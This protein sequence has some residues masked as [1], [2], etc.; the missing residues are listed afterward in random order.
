LLCINEEKIWIKCI[1]LTKENARLI[2]KHY[3]LLLP[4]T[5]SL[6]RSTFKFEAINHESFEGHTP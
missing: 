2:Q 5:P 1:R 3:W 4:P 6:Q